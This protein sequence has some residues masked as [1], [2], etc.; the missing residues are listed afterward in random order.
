MQS[1]EDAQY[2]IRWMDCCL[3]LINQRTFDNP[4]EKMRVRSVY[5]QARARFQKLA[6]GQPPSSAS[7]SARNKR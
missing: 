3:E 2:F 7:A 6:D 4:D 5:E 1:V